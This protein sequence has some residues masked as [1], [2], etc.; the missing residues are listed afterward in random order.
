MQFAAANEQ[1]NEAVEMRESRLLHGGHELFGA[2]HHYG[3]LS[4]RDGSEGY[5]RETVGKFPAPLVVD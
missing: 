4:C 5:I 1:V 3:K 2:G